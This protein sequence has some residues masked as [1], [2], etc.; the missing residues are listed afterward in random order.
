MDLLPHQQ[1]IPINKIQELTP[2]LAKSY[3]S[4]TI[5]TVQ[6]DVKELEALGLAVRNTDGV[7]ANI[8]ALSAFLPARKIKRQPSPQL[9]LL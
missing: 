2:R 1:P 9:T 6:R 3:A 4:K 5:R 7:K 8:T